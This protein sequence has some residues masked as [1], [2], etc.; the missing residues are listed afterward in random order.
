MG[1]FDSCMF[2]I[3]FKV[4]KLNILTV[5]IQPSVQYLGSLYNYIDFV[6]VI[7]LY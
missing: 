6:V 7:K 5:H 2:G 4:V 1:K 3:V